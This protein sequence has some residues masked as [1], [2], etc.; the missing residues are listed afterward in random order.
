MLSKQV[1]RWLVVVAAVAAIG[2][3]YVSPAYSQGKEEAK[4]ET[5]A[6]TKTEMSSYLVVSPHTPEECLA[7]LDG[8][9]AA[10]KDDLNNWYWGCM[11]GDHTGYEI[12]KAASEADALKNVPES[13]RTKA[14]AMK[15]NKFTAE[16]IASMH[17]MK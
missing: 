17:E 5:K 12:V 10:G 6:A 3:L 9:A 2:L 11:V 7:A 15:L 8:V 16:Q 14:R 1:L 4:T 13:L